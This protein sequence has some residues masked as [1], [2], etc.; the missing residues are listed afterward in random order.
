MI[1]SLALPTLPTPIPLLFQQR[2]W[3]PQKTGNSLSP[4][5]LTIWKYSHT[6]RLLRLLSKALKK[7]ASQP[8]KTQRQSGLRGHFTSTPWFPMDY[9]I[10]YQTPYLT[11]YL[12]PCQ[13]SYQTP[14]LAPSVI[15][16]NSADASPSKDPKTVFARKSPSSD[17]FMHGCS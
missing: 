6:K 16:F 9:L 4:R 12:V 8:K 13:K 2:D 3:F 7:Y 15:I 5:P 14:S 1:L 10:N 17:S 11:P